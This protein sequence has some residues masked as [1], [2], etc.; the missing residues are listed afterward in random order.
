MKVGTVNKITSIEKHGNEK[1]EYNFSKKRF[2]SNKYFQ[3]MIRDDYT[4]AYGN[5]YLRFFPTR[6]EEDMYS[7]HVKAGRR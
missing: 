3:N 2:I 6:G 5:T 4:N 1:K 7:I